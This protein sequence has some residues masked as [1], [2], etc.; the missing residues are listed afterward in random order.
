[1][2]K[3]LKNLALLAQKIRNDES[4]DEE[5]MKD[6]EEFL[7]KR[8][9]RFPKYFSSVINMECRLVIMKQLYERE[10]YQE[11]VMKMDQA[12]RDLHIMAADGIN[13]INR[14]CRSY[15]MEP[16]F[17]FPLIGN[18]ELM[19]R[20]QIEGNPIMERNAKDDRE[21][22][23]DAIYGFCKEVFL[24]S[25][26]R[27]RYNKMEEYSR[28]ERDQE[29]ASISNE[30]GYFNEKLSVDQLIALAKA[31]CDS[32]TDNSLGTSKFCR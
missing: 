5:D 17:E 2:S 31:E 19:P 32:H 28:E 4:L 27:E 18:R 8:I 29:L 6:M 21:L 26:S 12:R 11:K 9:E 3:I 25:Q 24:D 13:Q 14:L 20:A 10:D 1:M 16:I 30:N 22:A 15:D 7:M 23:A